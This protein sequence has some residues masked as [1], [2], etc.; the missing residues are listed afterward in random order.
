MQLKQAIEGSLPDIEVRG[1][2]YP[3][4]A[5]KAR[6]SQLITIVQ[7]SIIGVMI[8]GDKLFPMLGMQPPDMYEQ[9]RD[10]KFAVGM[11]AWFFGNMA[12]SSISNTGAF[13]VFYN[14]SLVFSKLDTG[15]MPN[16]SAIV[17]SI[18]A[19]SGSS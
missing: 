18:G 10:K 2:T 6:L 5:T 3:V 17:Q 12:S 11:A 19:L 9:V 15:Q 13:E 1:G 16:L 8:F 14:G 7:F 4:S